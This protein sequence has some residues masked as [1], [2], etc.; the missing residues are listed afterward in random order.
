MMI[1]AHRGASGEFPENSLLAF[2]QAI[3][4]GAEGIE[5]DIQFH[6]ASGEFVVLHDAYLDKTT[7]GA[8]HYSQYSINT[9]KQLHLGEEQNLSTLPEVMALIKGQVFVNIELKTSEH[10]QTALS[11]QLT[12]LNDILAHSIKYDNFS[13]QQIILSSF[14]HLALHLCQQK[15]PE[16]S[17]AALISHCPFDIATMVIELDVAFINP[18]INC[19]NKALID[20]AHQLGFKVLVYTVDRMQDIQRC[21]DY[22]VDGIFTN[23]PKKSRQLLDACKEK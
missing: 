20:N 23:Y 7:N 2:E 18:N 17:R 1:I 22:G 6:H 5:L 4:Q 16:F 9:L 14:N 8:G 15:L 19:L 3:S 21:L 11:H 13:S 12:K 10:S